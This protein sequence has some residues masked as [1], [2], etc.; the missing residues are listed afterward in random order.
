M[1]RRLLPVLAL[2]LAA[3]PA[4]AQERVLNVYNWSDYIDPYAVARFTRETGIRVRYDVYDSLET[5]EG[6]LAA[7]RSGYDII[8][9]TSEPTFA[10]LLRAG[11][12]REIDRERIPN[13]RNLDP[14]LMDRV[15]AIDPGNRHGAI[16]LWGTVG[17]GLRLDRVRAALPDVPLDGLD[18]L[19][20]PENAQ[21]LARCGIMVM[22]S[23]TDVLPSV[24]RWL[25]R[26]PN[27]NSA[28]DLRAAEQAL[29]GIR[30][31]V[32]AIIPSSAILDALATGEVCAAMTYSG[33]VIQAAARARE[34]NRGVE[35]GYVM[36]R[37]GAQLWFD[38]MAIPADAPNPEAAH[39]FINF[40]LQPDVM[41][42]I[43]NQVRY[44]NAVPASRPLVEEAVRN[45]PSVFPPAEALAAT[46]V[47][48]TPSREV[49]RLRTRLWSR[50]KAGR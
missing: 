6:R 17:L 37:Q 24:L 16:Y 43:T 1:L 34:A 30:R 10:R 48:G 28:E 41:A 25:G 36:P 27:G 14:V 3:L 29:M 13:W 49:E 4:A 32:R 45:D 7:G 50:F 11:A 42:G 9:P 39:A 8:V 19:L 33:D 20:K 5:L 12:L 21:R 40:L 18:V 2:L 15:A 47:A 26:D 31:H 23:P 22:D 38:M 35:I 44:P 46:F